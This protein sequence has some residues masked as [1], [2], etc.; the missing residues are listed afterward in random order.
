MRVTLALATMTLSVVSVASAHHSS[1]ASY[2]A[3]ES[4][5]IHGKVLQFAWTNPHCHVYIDVSGGP[6][7]GRT[8]AVEL[9]SPVALLNDGWTRT[10][11]APGDDVMM[12]VQPSRV[13]AA[14]GLCRKCPLR[15]NGRVTKPSGVNPTQ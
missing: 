8:Y 5:R 13:G 12:D 11:L 2:E 3:N 15:I 9:G 10:L 4:I 14:I 6:F 7:H 1:A